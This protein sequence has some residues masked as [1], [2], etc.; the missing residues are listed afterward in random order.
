[1]LSEQG[2]GLGRLLIPTVN[3]TDTH[4]LTHKHMSIRVN[5]PFVGKHQMKAAPIV[6]AYD[7]QRIRATY[8]PTIGL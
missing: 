1:M 4:M 7:R 6:P 3:S 2:S 8:L 5:N